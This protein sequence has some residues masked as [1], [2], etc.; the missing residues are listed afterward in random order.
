[1]T[2]GSM[3]AAA[4]R[5]LVDAGEAKPLLTGFDISPTLYAGQWWYVPSGSDDEADD[6]ADY[7]LA[8]PDMSAQL[9]RLRV[10]ADR[11]DA[12][13]GGSA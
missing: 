11:I 9:D 13:A 10:R 7:V 2:L 1:M 5:E 8:G 4:M 3:S 12:V 6:D